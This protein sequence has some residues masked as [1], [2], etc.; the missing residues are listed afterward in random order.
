MVFLYRQ[1]IQ[2][3]R[4]EDSYAVYVKSEATLPKTTQQ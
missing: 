4:V 3:L 1:Y 2:D